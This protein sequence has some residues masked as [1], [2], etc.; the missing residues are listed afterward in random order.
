MFFFPPVVWFAV[1]A[2]FS[3]LGFVEIPNFTGSTGTRLKQ[4]KL[5]GAAY[6][7]I[8]GLL[9]SG[10]VGG[11]LCQ[12]TVPFLGGKNITS[13]PDVIEPDGQKLGGA[14]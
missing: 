11:E 8:R 13:D 7:Q 14:R 9:F 2:V 3:F 10:R 1:L 12:N 5:S 4:E 6:L